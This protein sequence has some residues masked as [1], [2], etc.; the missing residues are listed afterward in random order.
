M[1]IKD[2][3]ITVIEKSLTPVIKQAEELKITNSEELKASVELL[4]TLNQWNDRVTEDKE[5]LTK[6]L[7]AT[8]KEIRGRYKPLE[9]QLET[10][11]TSVRSQMTSYQTQALKD[12]QDA[13]MKIAERVGEGKGHLKIETAVKQIEGLEAVE[14]SVVGVD[15]GAVAFV[16]VKK[17][18]VV[19][20]SL[21][22]LEYHLSNESKIRFVMKE[23]TELPG[24]RYWT[25]Q[26]PRNFR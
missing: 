19:D 15:D 1:K 16:E 6:P 17:F 25:E 10:A 18:E 11:I 3:E 2:K 22:P 5:K 12:R 14:S 24:V 8:L 4:T 20:L 21:L 23:G 13:E 26:S 9:E 7:N